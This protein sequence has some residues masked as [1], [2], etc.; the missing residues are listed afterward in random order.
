MATSIT[1]KR[2]T[3][4]GGL[5]RKMPGGTPVDNIWTFTDGDGAIIEIVDKKGPYIGRH[6]KIIPGADRT[7]AL[8]AIF[9]ESTVSEV[10]IDYGDITIN[11][12][13]NIPANK[14][15]VFRGSGALTGTGSVNGG[16]VIADAEAHIFKGTLTVQP[17]RVLNGELSMK[18]FGAVGDG[19]GDDQPAMQRCI[20]SGVASGIYNWYIPAGRYPLSKGL[21]WRK[22]DGAFLPNVKI[23]GAS[24]GYGNASPLNGTLLMPAGNTFAIGLERVKGLELYGIGGEGVNYAPS[25]LHGSN[26]AAFYEDP[27]ASYVSPGVRD[28]TY[29]PHAFIVIDPF[30]NAS[31]PIGK[32]YPGFESYYINTPAGGSTDVLIDGCWARSF[33][34][35]YCITPH[36]TP[37]NGDHIKI[38]NCWADGN[39]VGWSLGQSQNRTIQIDRCG[40]WGATETVV[41]CRTFGDGTS[42]MPE[43]TMMNVAG[44][45]KYL[46]KIAGFDQNNGICF[47]DCH[48]ELIWALGGAFSTEAGSE[49]AGH[50]KIQNCLVHFLGPSGGLT[51]GAKTIFKGRHLSISDSTL[52]NLAGETENRWYNIDAINMYSHN[53]TMEYAYTVGNAVS[54]YST[55]NYNFVGFGL[56]QKVSHSGACPVGFNRG[57]ESADKGWHVLGAMEYMEKASQYSRLIKMMPNQ[58]GG[59]WDYIPPGVYVGYLGNIQFSSLNTTLRTGTLQFTPN[60]DEVKRL[61]SKQVL[62]VLGNN[63]FGSPVYYDACHV[64]TVNVGTGVV[65]VNVLSRPS[66]GN[67][68]Q[69]ATNYQF[70]IMRVPAHYATDILGDI[71]SGSAVITNCDF[72]GNGTF[73]ETNNVAPKY[74]DSPF[75]PPFTRILSVDLNARTI[76]AS[77]A[78]TTTK[79]TVRVH[80]VAARKEMWYSN[81]LADAGID[82]LASNVGDVVYNNFANSS[83]DNVL[84]WECTKSG[85]FG[86]GR[87]GGG[88]S[89]KLSEWKAVLKVDPSGTDPISSTLTGDG[90]VAVPSGKFC[91]RILAKPSSALTGFKIGTTNG[92]EEIVSAQP[93]DAG[94]FQS[95]DVSRFADG[96]NLTLYIGGITS[97]T[98]IK[99]YYE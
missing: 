6:G 89:N 18:W 58:Q 43:V 19:T 46:C 86:I 53:T 57:G 52:F 33:V 10:V 28:D 98:D 15:I 75:F 38:V 96:G 27:A 97:S 49:Y 59:G 13:L 64:D 80:D 7:A 44:G 26:P 9:N 70:F 21:L 66:Y 61:Y 84:R 82:H 47:R 88:T 99:L 42:G 3:D 51:V 45:N 81:N 40:C 4:S 90:T 63:Q 69:T 30:S 48:L 68:F 34:V 5:Y 2:N 35:G 24:K 72:S 39:K 54:Q 77:H 60:S 20:Q 67:E 16:I 76:T 56:N 36:N 12:V 29:S 8:Q 95:F 37:Q 23:R 11:G 32:Q 50:L 62:F 22:A 55:C 14:R 74:I 71:S 41:D 91:K 25:S 93:V 87:Q 92:G 78:A 94:S 31:T 65:T 85:M 83:F 79:T 17:S 73:Y 1:L